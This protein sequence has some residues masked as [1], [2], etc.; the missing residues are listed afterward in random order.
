LIDTDGG[1]A[2]ESKTIGQKIREL[3]LSK[4][5]KQSELGEALSVAS[6]TISNWE[7]GR[8]LPSINELKRV[9][10]VFN[11]TL[12][13][14]YS[15]LE[16]EETVSPSKEKQV[17]N[18]TID[19]RPAG[20]DTSKFEYSMLSIAIITLFLSSVSRFIL[21]YVFLI[22]GS[23][24]MLSSVLMYLDKQRKISFSHYKKV[25][26]PAF[27]K[28]YYV[29]KDSF[30]RV[31]HHQRVINNLVVASLSFGIFAYLLA[32]II[33]IQY[34]YP[35]LHILA[36][37][38]ALAAIVIHFLSYQNVQ[39]K[40][41]S[42]RAIPYYG[43]MADLRYPIIFCTFLIDGL[44]MI[45]LA[46]IVIVM[47]ADEILLIALLGI[48]LSLAALASYTVLVL[49]NRF[50]ANLE[51]HFGEDEEKIERLII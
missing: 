45:A 34:D 38:Y 9:A 26:I 25:I 31:L 40:K 15:D 50:I 30:E 27:Y 2:M 28:V 36:S 33:F 39:K 3:R 37:I 5:L 35:L 7:N 14:F 21:Q 6:S 41:L 43:T 23:L 12:N 17:F 51:L 20:F 13:A 19:F 18:Q 42:S 4:D 10:A 32:I 8:R 29:H 47:I 44:A 16:Q 24:L 1:I 46:I 48:V 22:F 11:T 49:L